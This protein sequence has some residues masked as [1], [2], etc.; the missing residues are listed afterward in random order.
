[1]PEMK[2]GELRLIL[3]ICR[4]TFGFHKDQDRISLSQLEEMT[5]LSRQGVC[6]ARK[7]PYASRLVQRE[8]DGNSYRYWIEVV[9]EVDHPLVKEVD[10]GS[11]ASRP[12]VVNEVD[13]QKKTT[14]ENSQKSTP[15]R[16][17]KDVSKERDAPAVQVWTQ[18]TGERP[19]ISTLSNLKAWL[20]GDR[21]PEW[22][23][24]VFEKTIREAY[25]NVDRNAHRIRVGYLMDSYE[26]RLARHKRDTKKQTTPGRAVPD[27][28]ET[29]RRYARA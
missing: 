20:T 6:D 2:E 23:R 27:A 18:V 9:N 25:L 4:Q 29:K 26:R 10:H 14:K 28:E 8:K 17:D 11:Q 5:G 16:E 15:A 21:A 22:N 19:N 13:T 12:E 3:A 1:M 24:D 7:Q